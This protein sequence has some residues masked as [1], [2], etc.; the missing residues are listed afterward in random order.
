MVEHTI[1]DHLLAFRY[2]FKF[3]NSISHYFNVVNIYLVGVRQPPVDVQGHGLLDVPSQRRVAYTCTGD[4]VAAYQGDRATRDDPVAALQGQ[5][6]GAGVRKAY[7]GAPGKVVNLPGS[8]R[9]CLLA[10]SG[11]MHPIR[12]KVSEIDGMRVA[13]GRKRRQPSKLGACARSRGKSR[14]REDSDGIHEMLWAMTY[15]FVSSQ[16][17][18]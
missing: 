17:K 18:R 7:A 15:D 10:V 3:L 5:L 8:V 9:N 14:E 13:F 4:G 6:R 16:P 12:N 11:S 1:G 2:C